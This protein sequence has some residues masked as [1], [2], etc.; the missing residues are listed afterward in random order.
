MEGTLLSILVAEVRE[1]H[2]KKEKR[3]ILVLIFKGVLEDNNS[4]EL[5]WLKW[6]SVLGML[7]FLGVQPMG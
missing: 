6:N 1:G 7:L 5:D 2:Q 3:N 4:F